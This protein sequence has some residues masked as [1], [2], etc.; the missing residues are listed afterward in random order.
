MQV[1][2]I[3]VLVLV[4]AAVM[5][6][7][8]LS[9]FSSK[10]AAQSFDDSAIEMN[11]VEIQSNRYTKATPD[12][13]AKNR[14]SL[15]GYEKKMD[16]SAIEI[17]FNSDLNAIRI[18]DKANGYVWGA[19]PEEKGENL[20]TGWSNFANSLCSI[21]Y[22]NSNGSESRLSI[23]DRNVKSFYEWEDDS[24]I[25]TFNAT[26]AAISFDFKIKLKENSVT[27]SVV[28]DSLQENGDA[29][30]KALYFM[31]FLG[32]AYQ[33]EI[34]GYIFIPDGCGALMRF[35]K[36]SSYVTGFDSK[37]YGIDAGIDSLAPA[38]T[39][40]A[41]RINEY[42]VEPNKIT[43][44]VFGV[45]HGNEQNAILG[46]IGSGKE[47]SSVVA[48]PAGVVTNYNWVSA[49]FNYRQMYT[50]SV[51]GNGI[52]TVQLKANKM[53]PSVTYYFLNGK[54]ATYSG[55]ANEYR[56]QLL[57]KGELKLERKD[58]NIP[59]RIELVGATV[60]KGF[61]FNSVKTL[62]TADE[63]TEI[64][65]RL[66]KGGVENMTVVYRGWQ[67]GAL[68]KSDYGTYKAGSNIGGKSGL[69]KLEKK[70]KS[71]DS[72]LY[73]Y[74]DPI[75]ANEEQIYKSSDA[76]IGIE[77]SFISKTAA[78]TEQLYPTEFFAKV[79]R[80]LAVAQKGYGE[81]SLAMDGIGNNL[82]ADYSKKKEFSRDKT[83][84]SV[85]KVLSQRKTNALY[86]PNSYCWK[87]TT[88][89][90]DIPVNNS[91]Y[92]YETD[93]VPFM[94][95][96]L[97]GSI[98]Y[99]STFANQG[100]CS[101]NSILKMIEYGVYPS[102]ITM[103]ADNYQ[104]SNTAIS[105]Y[106]SLCFEDWEENILSIYK[107]VNKVLSAVEGSSIAEHKMLADGVARVTYSN[108]TIIYVNYLSEE[109]KVD[110]IV[111]PAQQYS[112]VS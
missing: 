26:K 70:I 22:Y 29:K 46:V 67:K 69:S 111:I 73:L 76:A 23:S 58:N 100:Y 93:T 10:D 85:T 45:V 96:V 60:K 31:P 97:K 89:F 40:Q 33:D 78:N 21:E 92:Q 98:D 77:Q 62:T 13:P 104:L 16:S 20:N 88:E 27:F 106:F 101:Q 82:Y 44:P 54:N 25:C 109:V 52:P 39:L 41:N 84:K 19:L 15:D 37:V 110:N 11:A 108:G 72:R 83:L 66:K 102:F 35:S 80:M 55:M 50:Q 105:D 8:S 64:I 7:T 6:C 95:M 28:K 103:A 24:V 57:E 63:G 51:S 42:L 81:Y 68:E 4:L 107:Q 99:Y 86:N 56:A 65:N 14:L 18:V 5:V 36:S 38:G 91:Q 12:V 34:N 90:F 112:V 48:S 2:K 49:R 3:K 17:W 30:I 87:Y 47:Y 53:S 32:S 75:L 79:S 9:V 43:M 59:L 74:I 71:L 1:S 61:L 94:Q